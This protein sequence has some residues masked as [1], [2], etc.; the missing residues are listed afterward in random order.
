MRTL[1]R[2]LAV[3][4]A[5]LFLSVRAE[6]T[7]QLPVANY[8]MQDYGAGTQNW[9][10]AQQGNDWMYVGNNYGLLEFDGTRWRL[11][12]IWNSTHIF[13]V[14]IGEA[15]RIF[16]GGDNEYGYFESDGL[17]GLVFRPLS[18]SLPEAYRN[19]G[20][21][22]GIGEVRNLVYFQCD[23]HIF[24]HNME[25]GS[26]SVIDGGMLIKACEQVGER[27]YIVGDKGVF[28]IE[29][30]SLVGPMKGSEALA[31]LEVRTAR[32]FDADKMLIGTSFGGLF[33]MDD[34]EV[35]PFHTDAD[36]YV[37]RNMFYSL[38]VSDSHIAL[39]TVTGGVAITGNDG[40]GAQYVGVRDGLQNSTSLS[41]FFDRFGNLWCGL[42]NGIDR[43]SVDSPQA[44][45]YGRFTSLGTGYCMFA[46][47]QT[48]YIGTN[49]G[50]FTASNPLSGSDED[51]G[52][53]PVAGS[54]GQVWSVGRIGDCVVCCH[55]KGLFCVEN[56]E[57]RPISKERG[58]WQLRTFPLSSDLAVA[59][60]YN[61]LYILRLKDGRPEIRNK[62]A[63]VDGPCK[64][65]E[66]DN[67]N[68]IW[69][70]TERG[71]E[72]LT[73]NGEM[74]RCS[75]ELITPKTEGKAYSNVIK[76]DGR[77]IISHADSSYATDESGRLT[78]NEGILKLCD[79]TGCF[80]NA[81]DRDE[82]GNVWYIVGDALKVRCKNQ[83]TGGYDLPPVLIWDIPGFYVYGYTNITTVGGG[84]AVVNCVQG[85][86]LANLRKT[87]ACRLLADP[88]LF[89]RELKSISS[90][91]V[92]VIYG[93]SYPAKPHDIEIPYNQNSVRLTYGCPLFRSVSAQY[94]CQL[95]REGENAEFS[96]W[97][98][99]IEKEYSFL[100]PGRY[101]FTVRMKGDY[102]TA[103]QTAR[104]EFRILP[105]WYRTWWAYS[106]WTILAAGALT[107]IIFVSHRRA[108]KRRERMQLTYALESQ[109]KEK[110][111]LQ[112]QNEKIETELKGKSQE[113]A[114]ILLN[115]L[116]RNDLIYKVKHDLSKIADDLQGNDTALALK[117][118]S[119]MQSRLTEDSAQKVNWGQFEQNFDIVN[120]KFM[121][122]L[123][124]RFP[125]ISANEKKLCVYIHMG[126][127]SKEIAPLMNISVRGVEML[128]YRMRK[129][130]DLQ[131]E[132]DLETVFKQLE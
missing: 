101:T 117:R 39:G 38:A 44:Q 126:L 123:Q 100:K 55:D 52:A 84:M 86:A 73:L 89:V 62:I 114:S 29:G 75:S 17:G 54:M 80:Y 59:G 130:M 53:R 115:N 2:H 70:A 22:W 34:G 35:R 124:A 83:R 121:K 41:L 6:A 105:P 33:I 132:D 119:S 116:E 65:F 67:N 25:D 32:R 79:G 63:G 15:G 88:K 109:Q 43:I 31:R 23:E 90:H 98:R 27:I 12:G 11:Y 24:V 58:F 91:D 87:Q 45:L 72:R 42:D 46:D 113:L 21:V 106:I 110:E 131:R 97:T 8:H 1:F 64:N 74:T 92:K 111:I 69:L 37:R 36:D 120:D 49:Q 20:S 99:N 14:R 51:L 77:I 71:V 118:I 50:L 81:I 125:W 96:E 94:S 102:D 66:I 103:P 68:R 16:V 122:K 76:F 128:R 26:V 78:S 13:S 107:S 127:I 61:G 95:R 10:I 19:F 104:L 40:R 82:D 30:L 112:L 4:A 85:F 9:C 93:Q 18:T 7:W 47:R 3:A 60:S 48:T 108:E 28:R 57:A 129:K 56:G 5:I